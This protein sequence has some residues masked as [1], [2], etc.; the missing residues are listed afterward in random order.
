MPYNSSLFVE[1][2]NNFF[3]ITVKEAAFTA[4]A[5]FFGD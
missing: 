4:K 3:A 1:L 5:N 2:L